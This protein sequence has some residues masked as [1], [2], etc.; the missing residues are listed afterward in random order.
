MGP[1]MEWKMEQ[2]RHSLDFSQ[3]LD[4][5]LFHRVKARNRQRI[6]S[7]MKQ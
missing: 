3:L 6:S 1:T 7:G 4:T 5:F 2:S